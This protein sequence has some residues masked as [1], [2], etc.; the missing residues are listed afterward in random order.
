MATIKR[1]RADGSWEY[2]QMTGEDVITLKN[3]VAAHLAD[4]VKHLKIGERA[5]WDAKE[6]P[7]GAQAKA[8]KAEQNA[9]EYAKQ[10]S[11]DNEYYLMVQMIP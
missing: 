2:I 7:E 6:T 9:K 4:E 8:D 5:K 3:D 10:Q 11:V 1:Q